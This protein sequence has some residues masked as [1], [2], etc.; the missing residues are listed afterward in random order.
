LILLYA[1]SHQSISAAAGHIIL[2]PVNQLLVRGKKIWSLTN[3]VFEPA[4]SQSLAQ[5]AH[6]CSSQ[7]QTNTNMCEKSKKKKSKVENTE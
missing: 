3:P 4:T 2:T 5:H 7:A 1:Y 6:H